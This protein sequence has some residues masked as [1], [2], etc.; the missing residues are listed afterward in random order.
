MKSLAWLCGSVLLCAGCTPTLDVRPN[1]GPGDGGFRYYLPKPY[2]LVEPVAM[3]AGAKDGA[4]PRGDLFKV[5]LQYLPDFAEQQAVNVRTGLGAAKVKLTL[6]QGWNLTAVDVDCDSKVSDNL[7]AVANLLKAAT[8]DGQTAGSKS[9]GIEDGPGGTTWRKPDGATHEFFVTASNVPI[10]YYEAVLGPDPYSGKKQLYGFRYVGFIP[11]ASCPIAP[12]GMESACCADGS[13]PLYG[14][15]FERGVM[16]FK[17]LENVIDPNNQRVPVQLSD[18]RADG[19]NTK[20]HPE[21]PNEPPPG[22]GS[23]P[24]SSQHLPDSHPS[25]RSSTKAPDRQVSVKVLSPLPTR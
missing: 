4:R 25:R 10:G 5:S 20:P 22:S 24:D 16:T 23:P 8:P 1:P 17:R 15:V 12:T 21:H 2:V 19:P 6:E 9:K 13:M 11:Y 7:N 3:E 14:L 18:T